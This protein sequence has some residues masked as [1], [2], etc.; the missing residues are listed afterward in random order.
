VALKNPP[1][2]SVSSSTSSL[3]VFD[4]QTGTATITVTPV[5]NFS[6][7][8]SFSCSGPTGITCSF[9]PSSVTPT[10]GEAATT[11]ATV[12]AGGSAT[13]G[14]VV[15]DATTSLG[16]SGTASH[17]SNAAP[18]IALTVAS[19]FSLAL[20]TS[21]FQ[22]TQGNSV[23][24]AVTVTLAGGFTGTVSFTCNDPAPESICTVP[25][26]INASGPV[27]FSIS[28][29]A[30]TASLRPPGRG[31]G[32]F[33]AALLPGLLG[34]MLTAGTRRRSLR[35]MRFLGLILVMGFSTMWLASCGGS[36]GGNSNK[37]TPTG[38]YTFT[39]SATSGGATV[40]SPQFTVT[41]GQ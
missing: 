24:V 37:G 7:P 20:P 40:T 9:S 33:Y 17:V 4:G 30:P 14:S 39:V 6:G 19:P 13:N 34:L 41:V 15:I 25:T 22:V 23:P 11:T 36:S 26:P 18:A 35:G 38:P 3:S 27:S 29:T 32:I 8:L 1:N 12:T 28:T 5:N 21:N 16:T 31:T 2:F 10:G